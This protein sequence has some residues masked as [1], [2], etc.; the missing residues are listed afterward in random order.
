MKTSATKKPPTLPVKESKVKVIRRRASHVKAAKKDESTVAEVLDLAPA[1]APVPP[2]FTVTIATGSEPIPPPPMG[3]E[4]QE[5]IKQE[6]LKMLQEMIRLG[7]HAAV[8]QELAKKELEATAETSREVKA[9][10]A[11]VEMVP[12]VP[13]APMAPQKRKLA[14]PELRKVVT[15]Y[16]KE[17]ERKEMRAA[18]VAKVL[19]GLRK[20]KGYSC[21]EDRVRALWKKLAEE[22]AA[23]ASK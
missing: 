23:K 10:E 19:Y 8:A 14:D 1:A 7:I 11:P 13:A 6:A 17:Y 3:P 15:A 9:V 21:S 18:T 12:H 5:L 2:P 20:I 4:V 22:K 16:I